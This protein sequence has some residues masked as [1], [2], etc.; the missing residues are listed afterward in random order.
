MKCPTC[1]F[2]NPSDSKFCKECGTRI[3]AAPQAQFTQTLEMRK[4]EM[5]TGFTFAGRY[6]IIEELG[7]GGMG[8]VY[9]AVDKRLNEE[10]ALKLIRPEIAVD[11]ATLERF[12]NE[13]KLARKISHRHVGRMYEF[14]EDNGRHYIT[15]EYV[16]GQDLRALT[17]Q[18]G[19]LTVGKAV[20]IAGQICEGLAEAHRLGVIHRDLKPSNIIIDKQGNARIMDFGIARSIHTKSQTSEGVIIGTP[21]YMSPEQ[22]E[23]KEVD[24]RSD[25]YSLGI[26]LFEMV[27]G[28]V[29]FEGDTPFTIGIK[30][31][32]EKPQNPKTLNPQIPDDLGR[33]ILKGLEKNRENRYPS[34]EAL[35][36]ELL[37]IEKA[38]PATDSSTVHKRPSTSRTITVNFQ[39]KKLVIPALGL[40]AL[41]LAGWAL[42]R[43]LPK[44]PAAA[45]PPGK[46]SLAVLYFENISGDQNLDA[47]KT[48]LTELLI[49]KLG[50]SRF[51]QVLDG[52][53]IYSL[54][55]R[56]NLD[57]AKKYTK[58]DLARVAGAGGANY[59]LSGSLMKAGQN[60]VI[61]MS[62]QRASTGEVISPISL[63]C[64]SEEQILSGVD[65]VAGRIKADLHLSSEQIAIDID[66]KADQITT[67]SA[68]AFKYYS[69]GRKL[70]VLEEY[71]KSIDLM[72]KA[73]A[74]DPE[75]AMAYRSMGSAYGNL[76]QSLDQRA[77]YQK[78]FDFKDRVSD[79]EKYVIEGD[80]FRLGEKTYGKAI[81][82]YQ[83]LLAL[84]PED[85]IA[86]T[87]LGVLYTS[88]E[89]W[90]KA[91]ERYQLLLKGNHPI[92]YGNL[93]ECLQAKGDLKK[94]RQILQDYLGR[95]ADTPPVRSR[96]AQVYAL[97]GRTDPALE[98]INRAFVPDSRDINV[99]FGRIEILFL[100][101]DLAAAEGALQ[102][103]LQNDNPTAVLMGIGG[104][105]RLYA[106]QG[107][108]GK[109]MEQL[110][111]GLD[112]ARKS[113]EKEAIVSNLLP[114]A[115]ID[116]KKGN[117]QEAIR[118]LEE[119]RRLAVEA[120]NP[121]MERI[122]LSALGLAQI[123]VKSIDR[124]ERTATE[125]MSLCEEAAN[126]NEIRYYLSLQG[127]IETERKNYA[128]AIEHLQ[129]AVSLAP[130]PLASSWNLD[131]I[132][133]LGEAYLR[134][135]DKEKALEQYQKIVSSPLAKLSNPYIYAT[136]FYEAGRICQD[137]GL[138]DRARE[139]YQK[140]IELWKNAD[141]DRPELRDARAR[142]AGLKNN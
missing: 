38:L 58:E 120:E 89:E 128:A 13:L 70:H 3:G 45:A 10:V 106:Y 125:L 105:G 81:E 22:V 57:D 27:T 35:R 95:V 88:L 21:E 17:R 48:G 96:L 20:S 7:G 136:G 114:Y 99:I 39:I 9:R 100:R 142:L 68:E 8:N 115:Y 117:F 140:F 23:G 64:S 60:I 76:R 63:E 84:Y 97:E 50:Q 92:V 123:G 139:N 5:T 134:S 124:A 32:S 43:L 11:K 71:Q 14:M 130:T 85:Y 75:F 65:D 47:W 102:K 107:R 42:L 121:G 29:P 103:M 132:A 41:F 80:Y 131:D 129:R 46:P 83:K 113:G 119:A 26:I 108:I 137:L 33:L 73:V 126:R 111:R 77:N 116:A 86:N 90:D 67:R 31:K 109:V 98:E 122:V 55:R 30:Q 79:R 112:L 4:E 49:T 19:R 44:K 40:V 2:E 56:L 66:K 104:L 25:L 36:A 101:D 6:Q 127:A 16:A 133:A 118:L 69:E 110:R 138:G 24:Q 78:A 54:L 74:L 141:P 82:S 62:L 51:I 72:K 28:R 59:T 91:I 37:K 87:N 15:M 94:A 1:Q 53:T 18:T 12:H 135:G 61:S 34:A 93:V 52:N